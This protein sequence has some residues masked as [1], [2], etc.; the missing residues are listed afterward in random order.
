M[1]SQALEEKLRAAGNLADE[2]VKPVEVALWLAALDKPDQDIA[3]YQAHLDEMAQR[4]AGLS[5]QVEKP[6]PRTS[7]QLPKPSSKTSFQLSMPSSR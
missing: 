3:P 2:D 4:A 6:S 1:D 7:F 5:Q